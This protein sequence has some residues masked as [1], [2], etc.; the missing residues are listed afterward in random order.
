MK[1]FLTPLLASAAMAALLFFSEPQPAFGASYVADTAADDPGIT[2]T[3]CTGA[4]NDC[5]LRGAITRA[6]AASSAGDVI[7]F[8][9]AVFPSGAPVAIP[10]ASVLPAL[11][12]GGD[13]IDGTGA[14]VIIDSTDEARGFNCVVIS[15][16]GNTVKRIQITDCSSAIILGSSGDNNVIGPDLV[17]F[18]N[19]A[20]F[21]TSAGSTGNAIVG[22]KVGTNAAGT[23]IHPDGGNSTGVSI[24]GATNTVGGA[25]V[26]D[27]NIISANTSGV[28][29]VGALAMGNIVT[30]NYIG[31]SASGLVDLG[32]T[33]YGVV[34][35]G[36]ASGN[37]IGGATAAAANLISGNSIANVFITGAGSNTI[38]GNIIGPD[39]TGSGATV[40]N[41]DGVF[42]SAS[43]PNNIIGPGNVISDGV[44]GVHFSGSASPGNAVKGNFIGTDLTGTT[45]VPNTGSGVFFESSASGNTVGGTNPGD[46]NVI[47]FNG[48]QGVLVS[49]A[50]VTGNAIRGNSIHDNTSA[51]EIDNASG[52]NTELAVP[53]ILYATVNGVGGTACANCVVEI[54]SDDASDAEFY[55]GSTLADGSGEYLLL[56]NIA[57]PNVTATNTNAGGNTS[58]LSA[59]KAGLDPDTDSDG[60]A[61]AFDNCPATPNSDQNDADGDGDGNACDN[62]P[63]TPNAN[64]D[65][66]DLDSVGDLCDNCYGTAN[67]ANQSQLLGIGN[68]SD[69]D[70]DGVPGSEPAV[71]SNWGGDAC[72]VDDDNDGLPDTMDSCRTLAEDY[73]GWQD[74][75]GCPDTDNDGDGICDPGLSSV[76]CSGSDSGKYCFDP[77][78]TLACH[79]APASDCRNVAED[80]DAFKDSD[81]C[82]EPDNDN[83]AFP[84]HADNCPGTGQIAGADGM[85]GAPQDLNHNGVRDI[86]TEA[87]FTTDD[88]VKTFEDYDGVLD[89]DGCHD[90]PGEDFDGDGYTDDDEALKI[91]TNAGYPCG[92]N[93]WPSNL[94]EPMPPAPPTNSLTIQDVTSFVA[95]VRHFDSSPGD[96]PLYNPRWD[97]RPGA[98]ALPKWINIQDVLQLVA[99]PTGNPP[100][101]NGARAFGQTCPL[102]P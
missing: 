93:G 53:T 47:A 5:S 80:Y 71:G 59:V 77:A 62:C 34:L 46:G 83:D 28:V 87:L 49:G 17:L 23:A 99:G 18:D 69:A 96:E 89:T 11:S 67:G 1:T 81:G 31:T 22:N 38:G 15:S 48:A 76:S 54:F 36:G 30:G 84:D 41:G 61:N 7:T 65:D 26:A 100:M 43:S 64:Q 72:D 102:P 2:L 68:Q 25:S 55:E 78:G 4:A 10:I 94:F 75:G 95:P 51:L 66:T 91:G 16:A 88:V 9:A 14:G 97:I 20:G 79:I 82:P 29:I 73:D 19:T 37:T 24:N 74:E 92:I 50:A 39:I 32:N 33:N 40:T 101:L 63:T 58:E 13:I 86:A 60:V 42:V 3:A 85:L 44:T 12:D 45:G 27:R 70:G 56:A 90:S 57:G 98:G 35:Q 6:N 52:G 8:D 21:S